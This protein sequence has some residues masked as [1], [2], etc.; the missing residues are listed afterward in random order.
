MTGAQA[1][2]HRGIISFQRIIRRD[3]VR[4][5]RGENH[6]QDDNR[7]RCA[8][9]PLPRKAQRDIKPTTHVGDQKIFAYE[10][11]LFRHI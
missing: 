5:Q 8:Q 9:R 11:N 7:A 4:E 1:L 3:Q 6:Q 10:G 2:Q